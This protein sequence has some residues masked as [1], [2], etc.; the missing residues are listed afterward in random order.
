MDAVLVRWVVAGGFVV[1]A[2]VIPDHHVPFVPF[3]P[4]FG[5]GLDHIGFEFGDQLGAFLRFGTDDEADFARVEIEGF[6]AGF[7]VGADNGVL[8]RRFVAV[9]GV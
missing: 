1:G 2:A 7:R 5:I 6:A 9:L 4:I 3:M 8:D